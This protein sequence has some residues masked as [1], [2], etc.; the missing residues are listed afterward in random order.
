MD[1]EI[2]KSA[3]IFAGG[4]FIDRAQCATHLRGQLAIECEI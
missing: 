2:V 4:A 1:N 3:V